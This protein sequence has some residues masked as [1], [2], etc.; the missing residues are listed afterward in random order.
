LNQK[1][2]NLSERI[3]KIETACKEIAQRKPRTC[4]NPALNGIQVLKSNKSIYC[5]NG[6]R[7]SMWNI[8]TLWTLPFSIHTVNT[9]CFLWTINSES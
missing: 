3:K 2:S 4:P 7:V 1:L 6:W 8:R 9:V 5:H